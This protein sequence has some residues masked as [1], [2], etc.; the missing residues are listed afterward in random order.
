MTEDDLI[1]L[2]SSARVM[3]K[4]PLAEMLAAALPTEDMQAVAELL[5]EVLA[6]YFSKAVGGPMLGREFRFADGSVL[7]WSEAGWAASTDENHPINTRR[8]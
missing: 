2:V 1:H 6:R 3:G 7:M 8:V 5:D 4:K